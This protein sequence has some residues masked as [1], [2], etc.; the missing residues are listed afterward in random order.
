[1]EQPEGIE[2]KRHPNYV[3]K[4][5]KALYGLKQAAAQWIPYLSQEILS[6]QPAP[7]VVYHKL[8]ISFRG[9][10]DSGH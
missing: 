7:A 5:E 3:R 6:A 4:I 1:M 8:S 10:G 2:A 9:I